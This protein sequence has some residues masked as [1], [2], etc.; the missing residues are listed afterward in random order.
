MIRN[1]NTKITMTKNEFSEENLIWA[2]DSKR[3]AKPSALLRELMMRQIAI[4]RDVPP[5]EDM[6]VHPIFGL[7]R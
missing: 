2:L 5:Q 7:K 3:S 4:P 1:M 6:A